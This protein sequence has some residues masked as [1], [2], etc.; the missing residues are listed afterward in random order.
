MKWKIKDRRKIEVPVDVK[1]PGL[2][3]NLI[4][5]LN[6]LMRHN[7]QLSY[8]T[9]D[10]Y[11]QAFERFIRFLA[12]EY[13]LQRLANMSGRHL[14]AYL[15]FLQERGASAS[16][17][18]TELS[19]IRF[20]HDAMDN[21]RHILPGNTSLRENHGIELEK[22]QFGGVDRRW[23]DEEYRRMVEHAVT[24]SRPDIACILQLGR[25]AG[26]RIHEA[27]RIDRAT[28][29]AA[30]RTGQLTIKGK[31]GRVRN[32]P[33]RSEILHVLNEVMRKVE[34]GNKLFVHA[35]RKAHEVIETVQQFI[36]RHREKFA[37]KDRGT[38][39]TFHGLRH[40]YAYEEYNW[41]ISK[42]MGESMARLEVS[43]MLGHSR[44]DV[45]KI[46]TYMDGDDEA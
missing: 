45:T 43:E 42:G 29:E 21:P 34:R 17:I 5:Q 14:A 15:R 36:I 44:I 28:A 24:L 16:T 11:Y 40:T 12:D 32:V 8:K 30:I 23:T 35:E 37:E 41:R 7:R 10:R 20:T 3:R 39:L 46:Y 33:V 22:R 25:H 9:R 6:K 1:N 27:V 4:D 26:L 31:G 19:A 18:K 38:S 2:Y 13:R